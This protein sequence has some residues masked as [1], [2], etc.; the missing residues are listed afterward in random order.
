MELRFE[1]GSQDR[2]RGHA[3]LYL[4][5]QG[6]PGTVL[7]TYVV[8]LPIPVD[9]SKYIPPMLA[10]SMGAQDVGDVSAVP[11]PPIPEQVASYEHLLRLADQRDDDL[12]FA[13]TADPARVDSLLHVTAQAAQAY[14]ELYTRRSAIPAEAPSAEAPSDLDVDAVLYSLMSEHDRLTELVKLTGKLRDAVD[15]GDRQR[16]E[17]TV[18]DI[19]KLA[20]HFSEKYRLDQFL[21]A[22]QM[23]GDRGRRLAELYVERCYHL[24]NEDYAGLA[25]VDE[26]I[27]ALSG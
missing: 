18:A 22:A 9:I 16:T 23:P 15:T 20:R 13:G 21:A 17:E 1:R 24:R 26:R 8:V 5:H 3:L 7:A 19:R 6:D 10:S 12:I 27:R 14:L 11:W 4:R 25:E 2:P